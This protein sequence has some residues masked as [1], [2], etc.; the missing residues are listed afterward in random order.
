MIFKI[1]V[2]ISPIYLQHDTYP[3]SSSQNDYSN[4]TSKCAPVRIPQPINTPNTDHQLSL[5][6][7]L[8]LFIILNFPFSFFSKTPK[9]SGSDSSAETSEKYYL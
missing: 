2:L 4:A 5:F 1:P 6:Y 9:L 7:R 3:T 8:L